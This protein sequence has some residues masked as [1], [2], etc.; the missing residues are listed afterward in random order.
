MFAS[1]GVAAVALVVG[2]LV[3]RKRRPVPT[4]TRRLLAGATWVLMA[5]FM[6][7]CLGCVVYETILRR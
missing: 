7:Y 3:A 5:N 6:A 2:V 1:S 4:W